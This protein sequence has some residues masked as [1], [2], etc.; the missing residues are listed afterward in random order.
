MFQT[1][2]DDLKLKLPDCS[3][4]SPAI[5]VFDKKL[6]DPLIH[7]LLYALDELLAAHGIG[8]LDVFE[9]FR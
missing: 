7:Q 4:N 2:L 8:V 1:V 6:C 3:D 5:E 9:K